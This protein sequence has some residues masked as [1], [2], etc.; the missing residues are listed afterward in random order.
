MSSSLN[1]QNLW[2]KS[3]QGALRSYNAQQRNAK[4]DIRMANSA[5][6]FSHNELPALIILQHN[7]KQ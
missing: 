3:K 6:P 5:K 7:R 4:T 1:K 2:K